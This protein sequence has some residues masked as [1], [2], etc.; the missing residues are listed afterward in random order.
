MEFRQSSTVILEDKMSTDDAVISAAIVSVGG[1]TGKYTDPDKKYGL[2]N[3][4]MKNRHGTPFEHAALKFYISAPIFVF[5]E[6]HR[7]RIGFSYNELS[8][9]YSEMKPIFWIPGP[10]RKM[11]PSA[12]H[13][14]A[15]PDFE[16]IDE[17]RYYTLIEIIKDA[18]YDDWN[19]YQYILQMGI[20]KE[21]ARTV[22]PVGIYSEMYVTCNPRSLMHY[23]SLRTKEETALFKSNPQAEI[24][25]VARKME[26]IFSEN[27]PLIHKAFVENKRVAP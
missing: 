11:I 17:E 8:A 2:I 12:K 27:Y 23:L 9:R 10:D 24:E 25:D 1:D 6:F 4:L 3:F 7:H 26:A 21:V 13:K 18:Y 16:P 20:A 19:K 14:S 22:L 15:H 5:R